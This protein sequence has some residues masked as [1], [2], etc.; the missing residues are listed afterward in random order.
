MPVPESD[1]LSLVD[2]MLIESTPPPR[3]PRPPA[4]AVDSSTSVGRAVAG[5][6]LAFEAIDESDRAREA[7]AWQDRQNRILEWRS[8]IN[9][10][11][12]LRQL[13]ENIGPAISRGAE[14]RR[15]YLALATAIATVEKVRRDA[16]RDLRAVAATAVRTAQLLTSCATAHTSDIVAATDAAL[17]RE[18]LT[19]NGAAARKI[20]GQTKLVLDLDEITATTAVEDWLA[21][22]G[23]AD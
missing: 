10:P 12:D 13:I 23:L 18:T 4:P 20:N 6:Y 16:R 11:E 22:H 5:F 21:R 3:P 2:S 7:A 15:K 1:L 17:R 19:I 8:R 9:T 14:S